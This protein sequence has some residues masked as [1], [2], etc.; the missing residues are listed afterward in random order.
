MPANPLDSVKGFGVTF[1]QIFK[2][3]ITQQYPEY[4]R[5]VYPRFRG[6]HRLHAARERAREVRRLLALRGGLPGRLH[7]R[8]RRAEN[9]ADNRVSPASATR[10]STR[11]T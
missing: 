1:K 9:T 11:S 5:P 4:K 2:K 8:R 3:P 6:R 10:A 7:P